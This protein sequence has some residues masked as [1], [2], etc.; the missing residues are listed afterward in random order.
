MKASVERQRQMESANKAPPMGA[1]SIKHHGNAAYVR[2]KN[3]GP[4]MAGRGV[5]HKKTS[6]QKNG[7]R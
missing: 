5:G 4:E 1:S 2:G 6:G 3:P 7:L